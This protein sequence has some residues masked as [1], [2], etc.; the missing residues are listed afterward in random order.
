MKKKGEK[1][2]EV[3]YI[4]VFRLKKNIF[5]QIISRINPVTNWIRRC[6]KFLLNN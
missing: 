2:Q 3:D 5:I 4:L 6:F 1:K